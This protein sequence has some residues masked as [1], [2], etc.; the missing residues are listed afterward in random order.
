LDRSRGRRPAQDGLRR[1]GGRSRDRRRS[2]CVSCAIPR[3]SSGERGRR[4][5]VHHA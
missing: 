1:S 4:G 2:R 5:G 3:G